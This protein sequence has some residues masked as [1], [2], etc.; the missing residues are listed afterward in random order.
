MYWLRED[1]SIGQYT[2]WGKGMTFSP[3]M[4]HRQIKYHSWRGKRRNRLQYN[5][6][7]HRHTQEYS[8]RPQSLTVHPN[9][10]F[11]WWDRFILGWIFGRFFICPNND[12]C[13]IRR[14][15]N[16]AEQWTTSTGNYA[17]TLGLILGLQLCGDFSERGFH[18]FSSTR[19]VYPPLAIKRFFLLFAMCS[20]FQ[21][22]TYYIYVAAYVYHP[23]CLSVTC[24]FCKL[25]VS[26]CHHPSKRK[27]RFS[28]VT[29]SAF[30]LMYIRDQQKTGGGEANGYVQVGFHFPG[31]PLTQI[32]RHRP[33][34]P[35][36]TQTR[37]IK[38]RVVSFSVAKP[39]LLLLPSSVKITVTNSSPIDR[40][41]SPFCG[42]SV[43]PR[44]HT[45]WPPS[46][47]RTVHSYRLYFPICIQI[48]KLSNRPCCRG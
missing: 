30:R 31:M 35:S 2:R 34:D 26:Q 15:T 17:G 18:F 24:Q 12:L 3:I 14:P 16:A 4:F 25:N 39:S 41:G 23:S 32:P 8:D 20:H 22:C 42:C 40:T 1:D 48:I 43:K 13:F 7:T 46:R 36:S 11:G 33:L 28:G 10:P 19:F 5:T 38:R 21:L 44:C 47:P 45:P 6:L 37:I 27:S 29:F 9:W